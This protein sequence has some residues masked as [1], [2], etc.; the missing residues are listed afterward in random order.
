M[1]WKRTQIGW[2]AL[3]IVVGFSLRAWFIFHAARIEGDSLVYGDIAKNLLTHGVYGF[4]QTGSGPL[5]TLIRLPGYPLFLAACF[6]VFGLEHYI[7]VLWVQAVIDM[8]TCGLAAGLAGRM[9][10]W[11]GGMGALWLGALCPFM[12][13]YVAA[14]LSETLSLFCVALAFF[15]LERWEAAGPGWNKWVWVIGAALGYAL[16]L[17]PEQG[18]LAAAVMPAM[19]WMSWRRPHVS[20]ARPLQQAQGRLFGKLR[21]GYGVPGGRSALGSGPVFV[22]AICVVLPLVPWTVRNWRTF[23]QFQ[24]LAP[25]YATDPGENVPLGFQRWFRT[26]AVDFASTE[27][28]YWNYNSAAIDIGTLP[29]RAFDNQEQYERTAAILEDYNQDYDATSELDA[30]FEALAKERIKAD[31]L[32]YYAVLPMARLMNMLLRP[33]LELMGISLEWWKWKENPRVAMFGWVYAGLNL[34]YFVLGGVGLWMW[35]KRGWNGERELAWTMMGYV[36]LRC[37]L[38]LTIDNSE[39]RYTLEFFPVLV[40]WAGALFSVDEYKLGKDA[41]SDAS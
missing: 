15:A 7:A 32:R 27:N 5:P 23:H 18:L 33:R 38:L 30:R 26:W 20:E 16:L 37:A 24:P 21:A 2:V 36:V 10:G 9:F 14:P 29:S 28:V 13:N 31:P 11:R 6:A 39:P 40:V 41:G 17:R 19:L 22:A 25:R 1:T 34:V 12:A 4:S 35:R 3:A 8:I